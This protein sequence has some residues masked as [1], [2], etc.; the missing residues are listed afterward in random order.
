MAA[1]S[2]L[3]YLFSRFPPPT[4]GGAGCV[5][6]NLSMRRYSSTILATATLLIASGVGDTAAAIRA[7]IAD[8][9]LH[10]GF[11]YAPSLGHVSER[12]APRSVID[13]GTGR[14]WRY[15]THFSSYNIAT[16][17]ACNPEDG[18]PNCVPVPD[19]QN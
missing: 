14:V 6:S 17:E 19:D 18:D 5:L 2:G 3:C 11:M 9:T 10:F 13:F 16:G 4:A 7:A 1:T 15:V 12:Y 8:K